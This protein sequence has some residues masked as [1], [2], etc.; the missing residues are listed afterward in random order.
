MSWKPSLISLY[1]PLSLSLGLFFPSPMTSTRCK[2]KGSN[3]LA[4]QQLTILSAEVS[5]LIRKTSSSDSHRLLLP[6]SNSSSSYREVR[7]GPGGR[8]ALD[9]APQPHPIS[10]RPSLPPSRLRLPSPPTPSVEAP[11]ATRDQKASPFGE[12]GD[13]GSFLEESEHSERGAAARGGRGKGRQ[14]GGERGTI[15]QNLCSKRSPSPLRASTAA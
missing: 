11:T 14:G 13:E 10:P 2:I 3:R 4:L 6:P 9:R 8:G 5:N 1:H 12:A 7:P 15:H